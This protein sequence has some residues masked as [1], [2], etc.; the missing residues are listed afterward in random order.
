MAEQ[1]A[2]E[3]WR[4][5]YGRKGTIVVGTVTIASIADFVDINDLGLGSVRSAYAYVTAT[6][7]PT[8]VYIESGTPN[9]L[10]FNTTGAQTF[11]VVADSQE[12]TGGD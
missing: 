6:G 7:T 8:G 1:T 3:T 5:H 12:S 11:T 4:D 10:I 2:T 9:R